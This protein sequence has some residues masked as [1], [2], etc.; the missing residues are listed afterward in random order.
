MSKIPSN[1]LTIPNVKSKRDIRIFQNGNCAISYRP[2]NMVKGYSKMT[3][4]FDHKNKMSSFCVYIVTIDNRVHFN[5]N[6]S[7]VTICLIHHI[8]PHPFRIAIDI[9]FRFGMC[10][11]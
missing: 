2:K 4:D 1:K 6:T 3:G 10:N 9:D 5:Q 8:L 11:S 7:I